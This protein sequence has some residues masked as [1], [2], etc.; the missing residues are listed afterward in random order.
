MPSY[1][2]RALSL[3]QLETPG[4]TRKI[5]VPLI[6]NLIG[7]NALSKISKLSIPVNSHGRARKEYGLDVK[8]P[9]G[10]K[11]IILADNSESKEDFM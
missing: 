10:H 3:I 9:T 11:S 8:A 1:P 5:L 6:P 4:N 2:N 7:K